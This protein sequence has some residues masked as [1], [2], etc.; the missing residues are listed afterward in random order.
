MIWLDHSLGHTIQYLSPSTKWNF[1]S[2]LAKSWWCCLDPVFFWTEHTRSPRHA[3]IQ[4]QL[5]GQLPP[6][7]DPLSTQGIA[8]L[9][10]YCF[11]RS[12]PSS[13]SSSSSSSPRRRRKRTKPS[14]PILLLPLAAAKGL[15][16]DVLCWPLLESGS[17]RYLL[18]NMSPSGD[19]ACNKQR[20]KMLT[21][22]HNLCAWS[23]E[24]CPSVRGKKSSVHRAIQRAS[25][26]LWSKTLFG[27]SFQGWRY[28][29]YYQAMQIFY[30]EKNP[31][32]YQTF[33]PCR[34]ASI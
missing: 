6:M 25:S 26:V 10:D 20:P 9:L 34:M 3:R 27:G 4:W 13:S 14:Q 18:C 12:F 22:I 1:S 17:H 31:P 2:P 8:R 32:N 7:L 33:D 5:T 19:I 16:C 29:P 30:A 24:C 28:I 15:D 23:A 21:E 11:V